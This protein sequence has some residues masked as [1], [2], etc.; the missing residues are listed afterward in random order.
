MYLDQNVLGLLAEGRIILK[1]KVDVRWVFSNE[2]LTEVARGDTKE[3][4]DVLR[5]LKAQRLLLKRDEEGRITEQWFIEEYADPGKLYS[6]FRQNPPAVD[7]AMFEGLIA[8]IFGSQDPNVAEAFPGDMAKQ[9]REHLKEIPRLE[10]IFGSSLEDLIRD[11]GEDALEKLAGTQPLE[12]R[13]KPLGFDRGQASNFADASN[14]LQALWEHANKYS[15]SP[16]SADQFFGFDP[17]DKRLFGYEKWPVFLGIS[18]CYSILNAIGFRP[19]AGL[20]R[21][22]RVPANMSDA[23]HV[24]YAAFCDALFSEDSR[25]CEKALAIYR[26]RQIGTGVVDVSKR[27]DG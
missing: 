27:V 5:T 24:A 9:V 1:P 15:P 12:N 22:N 16:I 10:D 23:H 21:T 20:A 4:L 19:D 6:E 17:P 18:T 14:P 7:P 11:A 8:K 26:Y 3:I 2:H 13:R 25:M